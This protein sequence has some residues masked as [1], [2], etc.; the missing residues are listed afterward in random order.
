[1]ELIS[2]NPTYLVAILGVL[3]LTFFVILKA[4]QRGIFLIGVVAATFLSL[5][6]LVIE[7]V[8]VTDAERIEAV[9]EDLRRAVAASDADGV[10]EHLAPDVEYVQGAESISGPATRAFIRAALSHT[11]FDFVRVKRLHTHAGQQSRRGT[12]EFQVATSGNSESQVAPLRFGTTNSSWSLGLVETSPK[13]WKVN[14]ITPTSLPMRT[15][16]ASLIDEDGRVR[17]AK[18]RVPRIPILRRRPPMPPRVPREPAP[19]T[20]TP[21]PEGV[22]ADAAGPIPPSS[23]RRY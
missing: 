7:H 16:L 11:Q 10:L 15:N 2:E 4:T 19:E 12:A 8:W 14:R 18:I 23:P 6:V 1:M 21:G 9:I 5:T 13:V 20:L 17:T 3:A 22:P